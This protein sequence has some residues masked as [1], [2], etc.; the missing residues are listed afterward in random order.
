MA[1]SESCLARPTISNSKIIRLPKTQLRELRKL[2]DK[3]SKAQR[4]KADA[5]RRAEEDQQQQQQEQK[6]A[7]MVDENETPRR[8]PSTP[9]LGRSRSRTHSRSPSLS[10]TA[11]RQKEQYSAIERR[12]AAYVYNPNIR[13]RSAIFARHQDPGTSSST[14]PTGTTIPEGNSWDFFTTATTAR[15]ATQPTP[16]YRESSLTRE[17]GYEYEDDTQLRNADDL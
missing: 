5:N 4:D 9:P 13:G 2:G 10:L 8:R 1:S 3:N 7:M 16:A 14:Q 15:P 6:D 17:Q 12:G 11:S